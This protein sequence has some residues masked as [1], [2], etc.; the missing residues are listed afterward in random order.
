MADVMRV[1]VETLR[2][3]QPGFTVLQ[4]I[5]RSAVRTLDSDLDRA[6]DCWGGDDTGAEFAKA[7][8]PAVTSVRA[9]LADLAAAIGSV[10]DAIGLVAQN[11]DASDGRAVSRIGGHS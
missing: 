7:Y 2:N 5:L 4:T 6:G 11:V 10:G 8:V 1:D 9:A 3:A